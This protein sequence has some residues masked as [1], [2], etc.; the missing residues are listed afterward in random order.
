MRDAEF[1]VL[2]DQWLQRPNR[3]KGV[4]LSK[5]VLVCGVQACS[6]VPVPLR[7]P[8]DFLWQ[9]SPFQLSSGG[10]GFIENAGVDYV[11][12]YWMGRYYGAIP[13]SPAQPA[14]RWHRH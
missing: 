9:R 7:P 4:N 2:L 10:D 14:S 8:A 12:P 11:L 5:T 3:D 13:E 6:P 1:V